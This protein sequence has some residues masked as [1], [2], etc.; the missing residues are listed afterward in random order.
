MLMTR[1]LSARA[2]V[3]S[4]PDPTRRNNTKAIGVRA[5]FHP[6][7]C[8]AAFKGGRAGLGDIKLRRA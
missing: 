1:W 8:A 7:K 3:M 2:E 5:R 4:S 6:V